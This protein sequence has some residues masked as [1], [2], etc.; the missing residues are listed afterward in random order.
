LRI[1]WLMSV[2]GEELSDVIEDFFLSLGARQHWEIQM[3][4][5]RTEF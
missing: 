5:L 1:R 2:L 3:N 4:Q